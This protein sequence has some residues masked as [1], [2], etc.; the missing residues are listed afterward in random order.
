VENVK[1][2]ED[3]TVANRGGHTIKIGDLG[4]VEDGTEE[5]ESYSFYDDTPAVFLNIR[6]QSG[7]NTVA[8]VQNLKQRLTE[9]LKTSPEGYHIEI[10]RD[11]S[12]FVEAA[13]DTVK[14]HLL[15]GGVLAAVVVY[16]FLANLRTTVIAALA[17][18]TSIVSAFALMYWAG[19]TLNG[20]TLLALTL[21]VGIVIDDAIVVLENIYRYIEEKDCTPYEAALAATKEIGLA[22]LAITLSLIAVFLPIA[23]MG[24]IV[25]RF[26][27]SFGITMAATILVSMLVSFTLT[28]MMAS[29]W[30]KAKRTKADAAPAAAPAHHTADSS[31]SRG[32]YHWIELAYLGLLRFSLRY[33]WLV[34]LVAVG[35]LGSIPVLFKHV[36]RSFLPEDDTSDFEVNLRAPE[37][38][39][40]EATRLRSP[41]RPPRAR[42]RPVG[43][44][45]LCPRE[46]AAEVRGSESADQCLA[47]GHLHRRR[48]GRRHP[49]RRRRP[50]PPDDRDRGGQDRRSPAHAPRGGRRRHVD[51][52]R[53]A[54]VRR[55][56]RPGQG[57]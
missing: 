21:A 19:F 41:G 48:H 26:L 9:L 49:V 44:D 25:G 33:R 37:G 7:T 38:T 50:R 36:P 28:P 8:V 52:R 42:I 57:G 4:T 45:E 40:L 22:V 17:I 34:V 13:V 23:F 47:G 10:V 11:Q 14:E 54:A 18:P 31:K 55:N 2:L 43:T 15:I 56:R 3:V 53:Q 35:L 32:L 20:I 1:A 12:T 29:R 16:F 46:R 51:H 27:Q 5:I 30:L 6:K 39:S 24:G